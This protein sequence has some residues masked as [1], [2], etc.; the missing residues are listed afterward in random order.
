MTFD[1]R[2]CR[3]GFEHLG[4]EPRWP[5]RPSSAW[6]SLGDLPATQHR[7]CWDWGAG[8]R[9]SRFMTHGLPQPNPD[10]DARSGQEA[11]EAGSDPL[12]SSMTAR[13]WASV[14]AFG[15]VLVLLIVFI[16]QNTR[17]V[18]VSFLGWNGTTPLAVALMIAAAAGLFLA[19]LA[20]TLRIL[21]LRRRV[22]REHRDR[23]TRAP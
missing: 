10:S 22:R 17:R 15:V 5:W 1:S 6:C 12:R 20:G 21:Q 16:A 19:V 14:V 4:R 18:T 8:E 23:G 3:W 11:L 7:P 13:A 2:S 9:V